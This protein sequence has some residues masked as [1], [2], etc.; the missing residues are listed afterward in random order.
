MAFEAPKQHKVAYALSVDIADY[1]RRHFETT[2]RTPRRLPRW[3]GAQLVMTT[4]G[5]RAGIRVVSS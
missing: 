4:L 1:Y 3:S 2:P 5:M